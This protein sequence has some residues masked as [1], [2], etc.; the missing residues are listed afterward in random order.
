MKS[1]TVFIPPT[2]QVILTECGVCKDFDPD[3]PEAVSGAQYISVNAL[4]DTGCSGVAISQRV[5]DA[6]GLVGNGVTDVH[7]AGE[8]YQSQY[9]PI[10]VKLPNNTNVHFLRATLA[11]THGFDILIGMQII[12]KGDFAVTNYEGQMCMTFRIPSIKR[13]NFVAENEKFSK[14][15]HIWAK[16]HILTCPCGSGKL[17]KNCHGK[18]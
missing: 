2:Q 4:W 12:S 10:A 17:Y 9:Y 13:E 7:N 3:D 16:K 6:L 1:L 8:T 15:F 18:D 5:I 11:K 14:M